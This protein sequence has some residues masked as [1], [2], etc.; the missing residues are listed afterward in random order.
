MLETKGVALLTIRA[1]C[2]EGSQQPLRAE[3]RL[4][5]DVAFG[6]RSTLTFVNADSVVDAVRDFLDS[7]L[8]SSSHDPTVTPVSRPGHWKHLSQNPLFSNLSERR[9]RK[10]ASKA[11]ENGTRPETSS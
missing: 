6:F 1:W 8:S 10:L 5:D 4:A 9:I 3:I 11:T 2:E 7:V